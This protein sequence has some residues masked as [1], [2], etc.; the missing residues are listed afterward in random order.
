[1][2][3]NRRQAGDELAKI[4]VSNHYSNPIICAI[5]R[6]GIEIGFYIAKKLKCRLNTITSKKLRAPNQPE[7]A[8]GAVAQDGTIYIDNSLVESLQINESYIENEIKKQ[9]SELSARN[10][11]YKKFSCDSNI[12]NNTVIISDDGIATGSTLKAAIL[13]LKKNHVKNIIIATPVVANDTKIELGKFVKNIISLNNPIF[14]SSVSSFYEN[15]PQLTHEE[16][17]DMLKKSIIKKID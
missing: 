11:M 1:M 8:I 13:S 10:N 9:L 3:K 2:F 12:Q 4:I 17:V 14:M 16:G 5:P 7:L 6:G 15:F